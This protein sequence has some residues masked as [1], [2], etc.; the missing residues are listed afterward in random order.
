MGKTLCFILQ[1]T[2]GFIWIAT[3]EGLSKYDGYRKLIGQNRMKKRQ[4][5]LRALKGAS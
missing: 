2:K 4:E 5:S 1:D 3:W